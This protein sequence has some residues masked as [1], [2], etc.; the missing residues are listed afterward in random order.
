MVK[1]SI[2]AAEAEKAEKAEKHK[3]PTARKYK[4]PQGPLASKMM[5]MSV[6]K[7]AIDKGYASTAE[8][9]Y[10]FGI[11]YPMT[12]ELFGTMQECGFIAAPTDEL[13][14]EVLITADEFKTL[15]GEFTGE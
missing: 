15:F 11:S 14:Q 13:K 4:L 7:H 5:L 3:K 6:L 10:C 8:V 1:A 12:L 2:A 9:Q